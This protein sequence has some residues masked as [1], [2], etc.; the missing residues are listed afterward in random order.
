MR[1]SE[2]MKLLACLAA[3]WAAAG[4]AGEIGDDYA[5]SY[6][7]S[8]PPT[9]P[10]PSKGKEPPAAPPEEQV[11]FEQACLDRINEERAALGRLP[12]ER[13]HSREAC[14]RHQVGLASFGAAEVEIG[15]LCGESYGGSA[16]GPGLAAEEVLA[17]LVLPSN[18]FFEGYV[19]GA[20]VLLLDEEAT[21]WVR[22]MLR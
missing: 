5:E 16:S 14:A 4:C 6:A 12:L 15:G 10:P 18:A 8:I 11:A 1:H 20:C 7:Q 21:P 17:E 19:L 2:G 22:I 3:A 13:W 9:E